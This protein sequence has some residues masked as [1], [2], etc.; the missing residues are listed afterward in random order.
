VQPGQPGSRGGWGGVH[1]VVA[2][3]D[4]EDVGEEE[5]DLVLRVLARRRGDVALDAADLLNL[6]CAHASALGDR[7]V[8][9]KR[10]GGRAL[11][12]D[13]LDTVLAEAHNVLVEMGELERETV[14]WGA[15]SLLSA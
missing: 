3:R 9:A 14:W 13:T 10:T 5:E 15:S 12:L 4:A 2:E 1:L 11:V 7:M 8:S 6:A